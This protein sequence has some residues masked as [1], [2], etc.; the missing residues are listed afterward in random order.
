MTCE[1]CGGPLTDRGAHGLGC[2]RCAQA[3]E[4]AAFGIAHRFE[5][6]RVEDHGT[7]SIAVVN[8]LTG[9][10]VSRH[11]NWAVAERTVNRLNNNLN[12]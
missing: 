7:G 6:R 11:R 3:E 12:W 8:V 9:A 1:W 5:A 2:E 4:D 10:I